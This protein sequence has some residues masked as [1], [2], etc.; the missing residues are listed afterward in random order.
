MEDMEGAGKGEIESEYIVYELFSRKMFLKGKCGLNLIK[1]E[2]GNQNDND[3]V[4]SI[5]VPKDKIK[6]TSDLW[7]NTGSFGKRVH[8][9]L[10]ACPRK[11][12]GIRLQPPLTSVFQSFPCTYCQL[13]SIWG[14]RVSVKNV[15]Y[16]RHRTEC[17][18]M[19]ENNQKKNRHLNSDLDKSQNGISVL[20]T[21]LFVFW[22]KVRVL[23]IDGDCSLMYWKEF[24]EMATV[25]VCLA[26]SENN[27]MYIL[28]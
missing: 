19:V 16:W 3:R 7:G 17:I 26:F 13:K 24:W 28:N 9:E 5:P 18:A 21:C 20:I 6:Q 27:V 2:I 4:V 1:S 11:C 22:R 23:D 8:W 25:I 10:K 12:P 15:S 14:Q